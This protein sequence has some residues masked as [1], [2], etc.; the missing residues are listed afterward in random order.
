MRGS[1]SKRGRERKRE[2]FWDLFYG[3]RGRENKVLPNFGKHGVVFARPV[4]RSVSI[5]TDN[6]CA[7]IYIENVSVCVI[8]CVRRMTPEIACL[9]AAATTSPYLVTII[10]YSIN[11]LYMVPSNPQKLLYTADSLPL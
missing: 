1:Q 9:L 2:I 10:K 11:F 6:L 8:Q 7:H 5:G 3:S 4:K